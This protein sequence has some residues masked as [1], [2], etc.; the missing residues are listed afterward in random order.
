[1]W[2]SLIF[3][4][5]ERLRLAVGKTQSAAGN[6]RRNDEPKRSERD[7]RINDDRTGCTSAVKHHRNEVDVEK[8]EQAPVDSADNYQNISD[9]IS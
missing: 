1:M 4:F 7:N 6:E 9:N 5:L 8:T 2:L 3:C